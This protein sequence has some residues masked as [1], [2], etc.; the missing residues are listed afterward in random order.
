MKNRTLQHAFPIVAAAIGNRF[1]IKVSVGGDQAYTTG[2]AIQLPAYD[3]D[4]PDYQDFAW[5][6]L[7]HESA[8]IRYS[9][10]TLDIGGSVLRRRLC[11]AIEDVRIEH[12]LAKDF[13]GTRLTLATVVDKMIANGGFTASSSDDHPANILYGYVLKSLRARVLGQAALKPL[14]ELTEA[15]LKAHFPK[16]AV[17]RLKGLLSEVPDGLTSESDCLHLADRILT[18]IQQE[19]EQPDQS[20]PSTP[21]SAADNPSSDDAETDQ[22]MTHRILMMTVILNRMKAALN[23]R[24]MTTNRRTLAMM[25]VKPENPIRARFLAALLTAGDGDLDQDVFETIKSALALDSDSVS[26]YVMPIGTEPP[27]DERAGLQLFQKVQGESGKIRAALQGLVQSHSLSRSRPGCR[28]R[29]DGKRLHR[30]RFG[31]TKVF[32][33]NTVKP[34]PN[35]AIHLLLDKSESMGY[36]VS[37]TAGT[38]VG[39]AYADGPGSDFGAGLGF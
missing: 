9:D 39:Y 25:T 1:G 23:P 27:T 35:T 3:G 6:L 7:A 28:G 10:F 36:P 32:Q 15:A 20:T 38:A 30:L 18:M 33:R 19:C 12:E 8:H 37:D 13:P 14:A 21:S 5:G 2:S 34:A 31:E 24:K 17:I 29:L 16:G 26:E 22:P 4:D 11:G